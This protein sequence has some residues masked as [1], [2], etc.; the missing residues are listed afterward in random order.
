MELVVQA[1][2]PLALALRLWW[3][4]HCCRR[5]LG[6]AGVAERRTAATVLGCL[7]QRWC[8]CAPRLTPCSALPPPACSLLSAPSSAAGDE[9]VASALRRQPLEPFWASRNR[10]RPPRVVDGPAPQHQQ[11]HGDQCGEDRGRGEDLCVCREHRLL[12]R[13]KLAP[14]SVYRRQTDERRRLAAQRRGAQ[15]H[16]AR[17][18]RQ[19]VSAS[20]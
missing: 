17:E 16:H 3:C 10:A 14:R 2:R 11:H 1:A 18:R 20:Q 4:L 8:L 6:R 9:L 19:D 12:N 5:A 7:A 15:R 13:D